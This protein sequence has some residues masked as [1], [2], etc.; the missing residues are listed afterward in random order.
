MSI[1]NLV[2]FI[3]IGFPFLAPVLMKTGMTIPAN[4]IY[5]TY[6]FTC[7][8]LA[9]RSW[10]VFGEQPAYPREVT[11]ID[12]LE[13]YEKATGF[14]SNDYFKAR[15]FIGNDMLGYKIAL[16]ERDVAI[17][18]SLLFFGIIFSL[19]GRKLFHLPW[20]I[21]VFLGILPLGMDGVSQLISQLPIP[22]MQQILP[23]RESTPLLR[24]ITGFLFGLTTA[25]FAYPL[26][27]ISMQDTIRLSR[28]KQELKIS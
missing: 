18:A 5:K 16:C 17:Y 12:G 14:N 28:S 10:F 6:S 21:W 4:W 27:E 23:Y 1:F 15:E 24:T 20:Y 13:S 19:T 2:I 3:Y 8:Q 25:W 26:V 7:H 22:F 9:F 11:S